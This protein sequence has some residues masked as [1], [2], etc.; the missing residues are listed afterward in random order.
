MM[1]AQWLAHF[2]RCAL[3]ALHHT[4]RLINKGKLMTI[5]SRLL[6]YAATLI[7]VIVCGY[8][9][10]PATNFAPQGVFL[11]TTLK[12]SIPIDPNSVNV[13]G[14]NNA[15][16]ELVGNIHVEAYVQN[17]PAATEQAVI[18][19]MKTIAAQNGANNV[20]INQAFNDPSSDTLHFY[21][22]AYRTL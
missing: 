19:Y 8:F 13:S 14:S 22:T 1:T 6:V 16:G 18:N 15:T 11:P 20:V 17:S 3:L 2:V 12:M 5:T 7:F 9:L 4:I 21:A 10:A